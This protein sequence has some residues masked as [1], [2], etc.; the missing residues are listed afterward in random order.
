MCSECRVLLQ[1]GPVHHPQL[2]CFVHISGRG[3]VLSSLQALSDLSD[4]G[5]QTDWSSNFERC[6]MTASDRRVLR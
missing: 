1:G 6:S 3:G 5:G 4:R 2:V